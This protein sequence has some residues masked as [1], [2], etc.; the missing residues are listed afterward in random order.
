MLHHWDHAVLIQELIQLVPNILEAMET[1]Q[2]HQLKQLLVLV[3]PKYARMHQIQSVPLL[4]V[5]L[6]PINVSQMVLDASQSHLVKTARLLSAA[7]EIR[8]AIP[9]KYV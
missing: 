7:K 5:K 1:A 8:P 3:K 4:H 9:I 6:S 2:H